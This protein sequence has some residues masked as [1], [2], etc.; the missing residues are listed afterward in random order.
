MPASSACPMP[1]SRPSSPRSPRRKPKIADYPFTTLHPEPR[2]RRASTGANS[3]SPTFPGL[4][5][6]AHEGAGLGDRFLGHVERCRVLLHLVDGTGE[7]PVADYRTVRDELAA[8]GA[9]P[10]REARDRGR[11]LQGRRDR[12]DGS[13]KAAKALA[14]G[15]RARSRSSSPRSAARASRTCCALLAGE[16]AAAKAADPNAVPARG[17]RAWRP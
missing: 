14:S 1:A 11:H 6:G 5:E 16:I 13:H 2:R 9:R 12:R 7:D 10:R 4:I 8:Y 3:C 15:R 17:G